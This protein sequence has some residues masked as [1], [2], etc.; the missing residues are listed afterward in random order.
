M[1]SI[2]ISKTSQIHS[3]MIRNCQTLVT[4]GFCKKTQ[5]LDYSQAS[6]PFPF[7]NRSINIFW[8]LFFIWNSE[9]ISYFGRGSW[10]NQYLLTIQ[11]NSFC[12]NTIICTI[13]SWKSIKAIF[14]FPLKDPIADLISCQ[15]SS[16]RPD[17]SPNI[18]RLDWMVNLQGLSENMIVPIQ[19]GIWWLIY[20]FLNWESWK[21][22]FLNFRGSGLLI[23]DFIQNTYFE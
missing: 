17:G 8:E 19:V 22:S 10:I 2:I 5:C 21:V 13:N 7:C 16:S 9:H 1:M 20:K 15:S 4:L 12:F 23:S 3:K 6:L 11:S 14:T 18:L